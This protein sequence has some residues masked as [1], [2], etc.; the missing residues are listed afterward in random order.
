MPNCC[1]D[2]VGDT[3]M[4]CLFKLSFFRFFF[5]DQNGPVYVNGVVFFFSFPTGTYTSAARRHGGTGAMHEHTCVRSENQRMDHHH[6]V[7]AHTSSVTGE[8][9]DLLRV[10]QAKGPQ[11]VK[12][13]RLSLLRPVTFYSAALHLHLADNTRGLTPPS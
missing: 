2:S 1:G 13:I 4:S 9:F 5:P 8:V 12:Q 7:C 3:F 6:S 10:G 11:S